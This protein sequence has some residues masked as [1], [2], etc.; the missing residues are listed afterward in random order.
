MTCKEKYKQ[1]KL[2][3]N[4]MT[5]MICFIDGTGYVKCYCYQDNKFLRET[6]FESMEN[7]YI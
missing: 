4:K 1:E 6:Y 3:N 2:I 7:K 5:R